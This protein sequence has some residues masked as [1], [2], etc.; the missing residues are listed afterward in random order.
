VLATIGFNWDDKKG[1]LTI[2]DRKGSFP[3]MLESRK[4][5]LLFINGNKASSET[6]NKIVNYSGKKLIVKL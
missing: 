2:N 6:A 3:G 1:T 4:F 5:K